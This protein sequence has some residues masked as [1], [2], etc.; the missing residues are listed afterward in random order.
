MKKLIRNFIRNFAKIIVA[1]K[2]SP[3]SILSGNNRDY[4]NE[5][6]MFRSDQMSSSHFI[7]Q[8]NKLLLID[9]TAV[10]LGQG[11]GEVIQYISAHPCFLSPKYLWGDGRGGADAA[12]DAAETN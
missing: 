12:V 7:V 6:T 9:V 11:Q 1:I 8:T 10:T 3:K 5:P 4:G 2:T